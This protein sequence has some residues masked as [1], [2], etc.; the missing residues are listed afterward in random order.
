MI[1]ESEEP[2]SQQHEAVSV[3]ASTP[4]VVSAPV[5]LKEDIKPP[6]ST[7]SA[8]AAEFLNPSAELKNSIN[9]QQLINESKAKTNTAQ[10][11]LAARELFSNVTPQK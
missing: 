8:A 10:N 4:M 2:E 3:S 7:M 6:I 11:L 1:D 9:L 5:T